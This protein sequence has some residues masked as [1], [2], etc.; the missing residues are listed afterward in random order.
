M[1]ICIHG[2][3]MIPEGEK[4]I[5]FICQLEE[6]YPGS[7]CRYARWCQKEGHYEA[8]VDKHGNMCKFFAISKPE[9]KVIVKKSVRKP[10]EKTPSLDLSSKKE[11]KIKDVSFSKRPS[12]KIFKKEEE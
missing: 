12:E 6:A 4:G 7:S 3:Q 10:S 11:E 2:K 9:E 5:Y 1:I 8:K